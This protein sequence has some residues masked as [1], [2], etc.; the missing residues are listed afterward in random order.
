MQAVDYERPLDWHGNRSAAHV[1][2]YVAWVTFVGMGPFRVRVFETKHLYFIVGRDLLANVLTVLDG[3]SGILGVR[4]T[5]AF[6]RFLRRLL[7]AP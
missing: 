5:N 6:E 1:P 2:I 3:P 4:K 7:Q